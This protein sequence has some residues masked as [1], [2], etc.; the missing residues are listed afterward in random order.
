[1]ELKPIKNYKKIDV[2]TQKDS[3]SNLIRF[4][5]ENKSFTLS[6]TLLILI[7]NM[8]NTFAITTEIMGDLPIITSG[9]YPTEVRFIDVLE[10]LSPYAIILSLITLITYNVRANKTQKTLT[11]ENE[12]ATF[13]KQR[14]Q[15]NIIILISITLLWLFSSFII[16]LAQ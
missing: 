5:I 11:L 16:L 7:T 4:L 14:I 9:L 1:M 15:E 10:K 6:L 12:K 8:K 3:T 13:K 2:P